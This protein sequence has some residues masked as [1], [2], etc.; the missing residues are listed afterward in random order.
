MIQSKSFKAWR[1]K[2]GA[3][4]LVAHTEYAEQIAALVAAEW[5]Q[6]CAGF[7][8]AMDFSKAF[9]HMSPALSKEAL[10]AAGWPKQVVELVVCCWQRQER[11][12]TYDGHM[13][14]ET[15]KSASGS[16][17]GRPVWHGNWSSDR[18]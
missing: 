14:R 3:G 11:Y 16:P 10:V 15:L 7:M 6:H 18:R 13:D 4:H 17:A 9:D 5:R 2:I 8:R 1:A 12:V